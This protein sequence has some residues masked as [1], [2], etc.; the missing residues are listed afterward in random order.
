MSTQPPSAAP[1]ES[2]R[3]LAIRIYVELV[4]RNVT[5]T[6]A[7][8]KMTANPETVAKVSFK[9]AEAFERAER[10]MKQASMPKNQDFDLRATDLTGLM[11]TRPD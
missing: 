2:L 6:E 10:E 9:L 8:A 3:E 11:T 5:V 1:A 4:C 7:S